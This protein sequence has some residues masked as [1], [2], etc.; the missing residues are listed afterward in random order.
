[1]EEDESQVAEITDIFRTF[2]YVESTS[3]R[4][5]KEKIIFLWFCPHLIVP[6]ASP[7]VLSLEN[8]KK[9]KLSFCILLV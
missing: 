6:L 9:S 8:E 3:A 7:K 4:Q 5:N 1:M 2:N